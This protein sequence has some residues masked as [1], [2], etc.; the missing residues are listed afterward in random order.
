MTSACKLLNAI[1]WSP[2]QCGHYEFTNQN[3]DKMVILGNNAF[4]CNVMQT[5]QGSFEVFL[6]TLVQTAIE[7][8]DLN[9]DFH[10]FDNARYLC[11][12]NCSIHVL[13]LIM[14]TVILSYL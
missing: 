12:K 8:H 3:P 14:P 6:K 1:S 5:K 4:P 9:M 10:S 7:P 11:E 13:Q 2:R